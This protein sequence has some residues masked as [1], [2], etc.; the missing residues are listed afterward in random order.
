MKKILYS[1]DFLAQPKQNRYIQTKLDFAIGLCTSKAKIMRSK[2]IT[3]AE[4]RE[5]VNNSDSGAYEIGNPNECEDR[6]RNH[7]PGGDRLLIC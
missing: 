7:S 2:F 3:N 6:S 4:T 5:I 1:V